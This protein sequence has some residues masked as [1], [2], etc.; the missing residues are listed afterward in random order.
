MK[1]NL[2]ILVIALLCLFAW[3]NIVSAAS[4]TP[5]F[6][7]GANNKGKLC[8][9]V[10]PGTTEFKITPPDTAFTGSFND[11]VLFVSIVKPSTLALLAGADKSFDFTSNI[12]VLGVVVKDGEDGA[13]FYDYRPS[14]SF[15]DKYLTTPNNLIGDGGTNKDISHMNFCYIRQTNVPEFPTLALPMGMIIGLIGAVLLIQ[16]TKEN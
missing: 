3:V 7:S 6:I 15:G 12:A 2:K 5:S 16:R 9:D 11:G 13:Y 8:A 4:V 10:I 1:F 14:G